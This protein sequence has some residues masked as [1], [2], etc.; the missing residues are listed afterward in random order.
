MAFNAYAEGYRGFDRKFSPRVVG[1]AL[2]LGR[3]P[4]L[5][6]VVL[7]APYCIGL[8]HAPRKTMVTSWTL[9]F[10]IAGVVYG[11]RLLPQPWRGIID[12]GVVVGLGIGLLSLLGRFAAALSGS[13]P[14]ER[15][16]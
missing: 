3:N 11:V 9:V 7:A 8:F 1:R 15:V 5:L 4:T 2:D 6:R 12:A 10:V 13:M 14:V 16:T